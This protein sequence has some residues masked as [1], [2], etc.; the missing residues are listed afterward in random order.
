MREL[1]ELSKY[2]Y[3][4]N[5]SFYCNDSATNDRMRVLLPE[6]D[7]PKLTLAEVQACMNG[8]FRDGKF[9]PN[10]RDAYLGMPIDSFRSLQP[11]SAVKLIKD[12]HAISGK[13]M[14]LRVD[15]VSDAR[16]LENFDV[17]I[18][19]TDRI[20]IVGPLAEKAP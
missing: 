12:V 4:R 9:A 20:D 5:L 6:I 17:D 14:V 1:R 10:C 19:W 16:F 3:L 15:T 13:F 8:Y 11:A 2:F 7:V 18:I